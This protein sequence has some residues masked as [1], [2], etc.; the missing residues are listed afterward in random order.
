[1]L[2]LLSPAKA[3]DFETPSTSSSA[4]QPFFLNDSQQLINELKKLTVSDIVNLMDLSEKLAQLNVNR[5][6][7]WQLPFTLDNAKQAILAFNGD[8]Y[9]GLNAQT[10]NEKKLQ[11]AQ[12]SIAILSGLY[13]LLRPLDL[14][15]PYRLEMGTKFQNTR[16][17]NLYEFWGDQ[18]TQTINNIVKEYKHTFILNLAS[19]E[20]FKVVKTKA[21]QVPLID[22]EFKDEKNGQYKII[23]FFAKRA[24]G[25]MARFILDSNAKTIEDLK[26]FNSEGYFFSAEQSSSQK[27]VFHRKEQ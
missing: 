10:L 5:Y 23:S 16:G 22:C 26:A 1:M 27:L 24:R 2:L 6:Y 11:L 4:T 18:I 3:L 20:Y 17:K 21:L 7:D 13:G 12:K 19:S 9:E 14:I 15:Q 8:V 25:L